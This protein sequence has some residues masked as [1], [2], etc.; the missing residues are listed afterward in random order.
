MQR[1]FTVGA[2]LL[3]L[4]P[5]AAAMALAQGS[6]PPG[7]TRD[8]G[9]VHSRWIAVDFQ[10][11]PIP[12]TTLMQ[13]RKF[14]DTLPHGRLVP[15]Y[16]RNLNL[17]GFKVSVS[18]EV[19]AG[20][21]P[22]GDDLTKF[23]KAVVGLPGTA[24]KTP[25]AAT[26]ASAPP[27][28]GGSPD[29]LGV[30]L[31]G[32]ER[33]DAFLK[34]LLDDD[35]AKTAQAARA[36]GDLHDA[37]KRLKDAADAFGEGYEQYVKRIKTLQGVVGASDDLRKIVFGVVMLNQARAQ[38]TRL[39]GRLDGA[40]RQAIQTGVDPAEL[41]KVWAA[42]KGAFEDAEKAHNAYEQAYATAADKR[43]EARGEIEALLGKARQAADIARAA[44][45]AAKPKEAKKLLGDYENAQRR[46][47]ALNALLAGVNTVHGDAMTARD[48]WAK[49]WQ[50]LKETYAKAASTAPGTADFNSKVLGA[51]EEL[52]GWYTDLMGRK[53]Q[54][55]YYVGCL[56]QAQT[57]GEQVK[58]TVKLAAE[59][60]KLGKPSA[61]DFPVGSYRT[62]GGFRLRWLT[63]AAVTF[64]DEQRFNI[65]ALP[66]TP[67]F[68]QLVKSTDSS[69]LSDA[70][71]LY[72][73]V[74]TGEDLSY[75]GAVGTNISGS[76]RRLY[77]GGVVSI[78]V[79]SDVAFALSTGLALGEV[80][81]L[82]RSVDPN[83]N[84][85]GQQ[86]SSIAKRKEV[87][88]GAYAGGG[89]TLR[90]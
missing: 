3:A 54:E 10:N 89:L 12:A 86:E 57:E 61:R 69:H 13:W 6:V 40:S 33:A 71:M 82:A 51:F 27:P 43:E 41:E 90:F 24:P 53:P 47:D 28:P 36:E 75:G 38:V 60:E 85:A 78:D 83:A 81:R 4:L 20:G 22:S 44:H 73:Q 68:A 35:L 52:H 88:A 8:P 63:L 2:V 32:V 11:G 65:R 55:W 46:V 37:Q 66:G 84:F 14:A 62:D 50:D 49:P 1:V 29:P 16:A 72:L 19:V 79:G 9:A 67:A 7:S 39:V 15:A 58:L 70:Q 21:Q 87:A 45:V 23:L 48:K 77:L 31:P 64:I 42:A 5:A 26:T 34:A 74:R 80:D 76:N 25:E 18:G 59:D 56:P 30:Y 17:V